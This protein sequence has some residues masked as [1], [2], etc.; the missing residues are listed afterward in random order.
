MGV[1]VV[2]VVVVVVGSVVLIEVFVVVLIAIF[3]LACPQL[4]TTVMRTC[5][6]SI[7]ALWVRTTKN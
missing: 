5:F 1:N 2:V 3:T 6:A 4:I 7:N